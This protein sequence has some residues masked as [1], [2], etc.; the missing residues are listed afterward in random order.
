M[1]AR[2]LA[3]LVA[4]AMVVG[5]VAYRQSRDED[6]GGNGGGSDPVVVCAAELGDV[7]GAV[8]GAT[9]EAAADTADRLVGAR[10]AADA[11]IDAWITP[12]PWGAM[13][14]SAR[15]SRLFGPSPTV[16]RSPL[17]AVVRK[18]TQP[19]GCP[20]PLAWRC[21]GDAAQAPAFR[22]AADGSAHPVGLS[23]RAAALAGFLDTPDYSRAEVEDGDG[24]V[25]LANLDA[26]LDAARG[27]QAAPLE[28]FLA[29][30]GAAAAAYLTT[31]AAARAASQSAVFDVVAL[32]PAVVVGVVVSSTSPRGRRAVD[33]GDLTDA[34]VERGWERGAAPGGG[35]LPEPGVLLALRDFVR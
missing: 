12:G 13:V 31:A 25:W 15:T 26:R 6:G 20:R 33:R 34:L 9:V 4:V 16:A 35:G 14:D 17:V 23:V 24:A 7:C 8:E 5:A 28:R 30:Q 32:E 11:G 22:L 18:G 21:I 27:F 3:L 19:G 2:I 1:A 10:T 29:T